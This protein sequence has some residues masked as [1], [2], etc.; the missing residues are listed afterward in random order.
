MKAILKRPA[1]TVDASL[2]V[3]EVLDAKPDEVAS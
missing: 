2:E 1:T 3:D